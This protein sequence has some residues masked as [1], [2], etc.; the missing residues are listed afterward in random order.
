MFN[1]DSEFYGG[2][3]MGNGSELILA[4]D[5]PWMNRQ[6]SISLTLPPLSA[7]VITREA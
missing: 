1:S 3:N 7:I 2:S 6:Y 5:R 4:E